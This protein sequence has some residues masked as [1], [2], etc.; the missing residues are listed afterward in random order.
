MQGQKELAQEAAKFPGGE[1]L[2]E[3]F[4]LDVRNEESVKQGREF[5]ESKLKQFNAKGKRVSR[6]TRWTEA[7]R[8]NSLGSTTNKLGCATDK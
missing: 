2:L 8:S 3:T 1:D 7:M 5:V 6:G 4:N